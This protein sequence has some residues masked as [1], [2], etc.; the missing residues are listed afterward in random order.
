MHTEGQLGMY[1][2]FW[3]CLVVHLCVYWCMWCTCSA[4]VVHVYVNGASM[5]TCVFGDACM[6]I[7][8]CNWWCMWCT[9]V[10][11]VH[12]C[13]SMP[14]CFWLCMWCKYV[15]MVHVCVYSSS[16]HTCVFGVCVYGTHICTFDWSCINV[17]VVHLCTHVCIWWCMQW[18]L[19]YIVHICV[20]SASMKST[21]KV[22][23]TWKAPEKWKSP[24]KDVHHMHH[25]L[26][27]HLYAPYTHTCTTKHT[28]VHR[29]TIY[30]Y[31]HHQTQMCLHRCTKYTY[32][33][34]MHHQT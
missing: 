3:Q 20:Y 11:V 29:C 34:H 21:W 1:L 18:M 31:M 2:N 8:T 33:H 4:N 23:S 14:T 10:H 26:Q 13:I 32:M 19:V 24:E 17:Y 30:T 12:V 27:M 6:C 9:H 16:I 15:N 7:C 22:K 25:Q 5:H 28:C